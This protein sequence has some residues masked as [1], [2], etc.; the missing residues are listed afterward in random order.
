MR[1]NP[2]E[3]A[4]NAMEPFKTG[5][6]T[7]GAKPVAQ[8]KLLSGLSGRP[9]GWSGEHLQARRARLQARRADVEA[10]CIS[11]P[12]LVAPLARPVAPP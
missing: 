10:L 4:K 5:A 3:G 2:L 9:V 11:L 12:R 8:R 6:A 7:L 1:R